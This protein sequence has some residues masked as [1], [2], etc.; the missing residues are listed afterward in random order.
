MAPF[1]LVIHDLNKDGFPD[2]AIANSDASDVSVLWGNGDGTF[3]DPAM[4]YAVGDFPVGIAAG[5]I[6]SDQAPDLAVANEGSQGVSILIGKGAAEAFDGPS[7]T[8][9]A[10]APAAIVLADFNGDDR[11]DIATSELFDDGV[12]SM[13]GNGDATGTFRDARTTSVPG[14][15]FGIAGGDVDGDGD[16]DLVVAISDASRIGVLKGS[17]D[18]SFVGL[19]CTGTLPPAGCFTV[20]RSPAGVTLGDLNGDSRLDTVVANEDADTASLMLNDGS[21]GFTSAGQLNTGLF[22]FPE[23][24]V[25]A[26][27]NGDGAADIAVVNSENDN[28][29]LFI[30]HGD[31]TFDSAVFFAVQEGGTPVA[32]A[33]A[34]LNADGL[35]DI[36]TANADLASISILMNQSEAAPP[37]SPTPSF[38]TSRTATRTASPSPTPTPSPSPTPSRTPTHTPTPTATPSV[39]PTVTLTPQVVHIDAGSAIGGPGNAVNVPVHLTTSGANVAATA[40]DLSFDADVLALD[41]HTC[42][43]TIAS[44]NVLTANPLQ[45]GTVRVFVQPGP[46]KAAL[47][48]G[49]LYTCTFRVAR[50]AS[51]NTYVIGNANVRAF[52]PTGEEL[53][54]VSGGS[55]SITVS[56]ITQ[57]CPGDCDGDRRVTVDELVTGVS[58]ALGHIPA[59][60]CL[61]FDT[62]DD[63]RVTV[64]ELVIAVNRAL[65]GC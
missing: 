36:V 23:A 34:D 19:D 58:I 59:T 17:G 47:V 64:D 1:D 56:L 65:Q 26:D 22:S 46:S 37:G 15:P 55:G 29:A 33:T 16:I 6:T 30:G 42:R 54:Y 41:P 2:I 39:T 51:P 44:D 3:R 28:I 53:D 18:G 52:A 9:S 63:G 48:S 20:G 24:S 45:A 61:Q 43:L 13:L 7:N 4:T 31:G 10:G 14:S 38:T 27:F 40:N 8:A 49:P 35:P 57:T 60:R 12:T 62:N 50:A 25:I 21:G 32:I 5:L 11:L